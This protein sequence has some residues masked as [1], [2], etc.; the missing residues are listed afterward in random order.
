[1]SENFYAKNK[2]TFEADNKKPE[3]D[4]VIWIALG[5]SAKISY[6]IRLNIKTGNLELV[7]DD[8]NIVGYLFGDE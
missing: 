5:S 3:S 1:M 6:R 2:K 8:N 4:D 7:D